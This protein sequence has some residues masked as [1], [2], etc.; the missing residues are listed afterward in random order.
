MKQCVTALPFHFAET[1]SLLVTLLTVETSYTLFYTMY[2]NNVYLM[3]TALFFVATFSVFVLSYFWAA[4]EEWKLG[5]F[6]LLFARGWRHDFQ[7][8]WQPCV[9]HQKQPT[10][11]QM[12]TAVEFKLL[13]AAS[14]LDSWDLYETVDVLCTWLS[15]QQRYRQHK[16]K[17]LQMCSRRMMK[18]LI[19]YV[20]TVILLWESIVSL[21]GPHKAIKPVI[22]ARKF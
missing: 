20:M 3:S 1:F 21:V 5:D 14:W 10:M 18:L 17:L 15:L 8:I 7:K 13:E 11:Q 2:N 6:G 12:Q 16:Q 4:N 19:K 22:S 9:W